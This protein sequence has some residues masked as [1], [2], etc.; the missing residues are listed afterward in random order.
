MTIQKYFYFLGCPEELFSTLNEIKLASYQ[1]IAILNAIDSFITYICLETSNTNNFFVYRTA[2]KNYFQL[3][4]FNFLIPEKFFQGIPM[5][6][7]YDNFDEHKKFYDSFKAIFL[8][9][10]EFLQICDFWYTS[11]KNVSNEKNLLNDKNVNLQMNFSEISFVIVFLSNTSLNYQNFPTL[12][13]ALEN[14]D[15]QENFSKFSWLT[16]ELTNLFTSLD[17][18]TLFLHQETLLKNLE[19]KIFRHEF[20]PKI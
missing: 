16:V 7:S 3:F 4:K 2:V 14:K 9:Y 19:K 17:V 20:I 11:K 15:F 10:K 12:K 13:V 5:R 8:V 18:I 6:P 1:P